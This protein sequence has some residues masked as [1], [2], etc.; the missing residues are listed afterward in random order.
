[1]KAAQTILL[2]GSLL[3]VAGPG[4]AGRAQAE[5][6]PAGTRFF[7]NYPHQVP[8]DYVYRTGRIFAPPSGGPP[9]PAQSAAPEPAAPDGQAFRLLIGELAGRLL[10]SGEEEIADQYRLAVSTF[11]NLNNLYRTSALGRYLSEQL[12]GELQTAGVEVVELRRTPSIMMSQAHG[13]YA[14]SRDMDELA[15]LHAVQATLV[16]TYTVA[17]EQLFIN[18]RLLRN[19]DNKVLASAGLALP[20]D[21]LLRSL[22]ADEAMPAGRATPVRIRAYHENGNGA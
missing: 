14:L 7:Y 4:H 22:L 13:E 16:G 19:R 5:S 18:A 8:P 11:V 10:A 17:A 1:M 2:A 6:P 12:M 3:L 9:P 15:F 21:P 20:L